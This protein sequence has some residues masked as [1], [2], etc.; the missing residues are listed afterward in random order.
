MS[1]QGALHNQFCVHHQVAQFQQVRT[2]MKVGVVLMDF[3]LQQLDAVLR[4]L[5]AFVGA[6][7]TH[8]VPHEMAQFRPVVRD[9]DLLVR[10]RHA[11]FVPGGQGR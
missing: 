10:I 4:A 8:V 9:D 6:H 2:D 3:I 11:A 1:Q 7:D 5:Q